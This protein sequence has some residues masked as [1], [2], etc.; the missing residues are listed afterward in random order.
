[1]L[2][3]G[4]AWGDGKVFFCDVGSAV[5]LPEKGTV[6]WAENAGSPV[7][8]TREYTHTSAPSA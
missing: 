5:P 8:G 3:K 1:M 4:G 6:G 2:C 7:L